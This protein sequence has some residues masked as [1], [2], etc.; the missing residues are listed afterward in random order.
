MTAPDTTTT[1]TTASQPPTT[2]TSSPSQITILVASTN[3]VKITAA[4]R[5]FARMF[6][7][8]TPRPI[9]HGISFPSGV[10][11][12][13]FTDATT[14]RGAAN[15]AAAARALDPTPQTGGEGGKYDYFVGIEGGVG[16]HP[17]EEM[18]GLGVGGEMMRSFAWVVV[19][20]RDGS[21]VGRARTATYFLPKETAGLV[22][23]GM[24]LGKADEVV[25]GG[26]NSK[27]KNGSV[28]LLTGDVVDRAGYY[29][30]AV[31]LALIPFREENGGLTF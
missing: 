11:D 18:D 31:V 15:R 16:E 25:F 6:P 13:P 22:R 27:Q 8:A 26:R 17:A 21:R 10:P 5:A 9:A 19:L 4:A 3:P 1:T 12:Q 2:T 29:E 14:L 23:G 30:E 7:S 24:E 20:G 28:G